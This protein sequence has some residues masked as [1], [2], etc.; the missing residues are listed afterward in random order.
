MSLCSADQANPAMDERLSGY[1]VFWD[2]DS[3]HVSFLEGKYSTPF[4]L[5]SV[6]SPEFQSGI[7]LL[8][9]LPNQPF[10]SDSAF[11]QSEQGTRLEFNPY[12]FLSP[13]ERNWQWNPGPI[14]V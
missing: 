6:D 14:P 5:H 4:R 7:A 12:H 9:V 2:H 10:N 11:Y 1:R 13:E 8:L 3:T